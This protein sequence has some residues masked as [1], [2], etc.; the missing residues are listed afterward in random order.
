MTSDRTAVRPVR[1]AAS[2]RVRLRALDG[3]HTVLRRDTV[4]AEEPLQIRV[5]S[6]DGPE[7]VAVT[8]RTPGNDFDLAAGWLFG[9]G[10]IRCRQDVAR[11]DYCTGIESVEQEFNVVTAWV[12][13][14]VPDLGAFARRGTISSACGVCAKTTLEEIRG[15]GVA[16]LD[17]GPTVPAQVVYRLPDTLREAQPTFAATGGLHAAGLFDTSGGMLLAAEDVGR[18]NAVD[19]V[20]GA[21]L[22]RGLFP[23]RN[24]VLMVSGRAGFEIAQKA[25]TA[26]IPIL[27]AVSA[28][29]SM[30]V[31]LAE[32]F[33]LTLVGFVRHRRANV[34]AGLDRITG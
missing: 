11:I 12:R 3:E 24:T 2:A 10:I 13:S 18:H 23:L 8:M 26:G 9:E 28:P 4:A 30:A 16:P 22:L 31:S 5:D 20:I 29:S 32:E 19:K 7:P 1:S 21:A 25:V 34:Y 14:P 6:G 17:D 27:A 15:D 33:N